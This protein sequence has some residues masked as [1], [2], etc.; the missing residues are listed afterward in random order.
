MSENSKR[1]PNLIEDD[2]YAPIPNQVELKF[3][4]Q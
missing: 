2:L 1:P 3:Y 4:L